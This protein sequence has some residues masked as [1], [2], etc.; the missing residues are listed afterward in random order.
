MDKE[1]P[2]K[3]KFDMSRATRV[4][5]LVSVELGFV[6]EAYSRKAYLNEGLVL[7]SAFRE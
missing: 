1:I 3:L 5:H 2:G 6:S 7:Y 4:S